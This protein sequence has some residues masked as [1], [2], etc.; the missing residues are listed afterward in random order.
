MLALFIIHRYV[1][2]TNNLYVFTSPPVM[3]DYIDSGKDAII[4]MDENNQ[5]SVGYMTNDSGNSNFVTPS[6]KELKEYVES[7]ISIINSGDF[8]SNTGVG[9]NV[10]SEVSVSLGPTEPNPSNSATNSDPAS[11]SDPSK[12][13]EESNDPTSKNEN[14]NKNKDSNSSGNKKS[15]DKNSNKKDFLDSNSSA[16]SIISYALILPVLLM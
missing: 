12:P 5:V 14:S 13:V 6:K 16:N 8:E 15:N 11:N 3:V 7:G 4:R 2:C 10:G 9:N 1:K